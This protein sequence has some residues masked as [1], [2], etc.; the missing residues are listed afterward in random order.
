M[1]LAVYFSVLAVAGCEPMGNRD[2]KASPIPT[3]GTPSD[4]ALAS[5]QVEGVSVSPLFPCTYFG[6]HGEATLVIASATVAASSDGGPDASG[7]G[8]DA[9][10]AST[11]LSPLTARLS[12]YRNGGVGFGR[13]T[14]AEMPDQWSL[15]VQ[16]ADYK[17]ADD[18]VKIVADELS[19]E[20]SREGVLVVIAP[21]AVACAN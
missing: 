2:C 3:T 10:A 20:N 16:I 19:V 18:V 8:G 7:D 21:T 11:L 15:F 12:T 5:S 1:R 6:E 13:G 14:C 9:G 17:A 4:F